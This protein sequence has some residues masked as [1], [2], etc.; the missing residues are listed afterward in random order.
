[1]VVSDWVSRIFTSRITWRRIYFVFMSSQF[2]LR[3]RHYVFA[4]SVPSSVRPV[5]RPVPNIFLSPRKNTERISM[6]FAGGSHYHEQINYYILGE[7][8]TGTREQDTR[9][10]SNRIKVSRFSRPVKQ[11]PTPGEWIHSHINYMTRLYRRCDHGHNGT[12]QVLD[13]DR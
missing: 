10:N 13:N 9:E 3:R 6:K 1:M 5:F 4:L 8:G 7:I 11:V 2:M 12:W